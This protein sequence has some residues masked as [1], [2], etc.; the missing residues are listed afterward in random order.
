MPLAVGEKL[1]PYEILGPLGAGGMGAVYRARDTRLGREVAIKISSAQFTDR[2]EREARAVAALNHPNICHL[3]D[4]GALPSGAGYLVMELIEGQTLTDRIRQGPIPTEE[5]LH[6]AAQIRDALEAAHEKLITHRDLKPGNVM[7]TSES[8]SSGS[9][10]K[11]LDFGLAKQGR[12]GPVSGS[13]AAQSPT[14]SPTLSMAATEAGMILG[15][16]A[17][18]APE[19]AKGKPVDKRADIWAFG[20]VLYEMLTGERPF[21]GEDAGDILASVIKEQPKF[22]KVPAKVRPLIESCLEK[23]PN[24]RLRDIGDAWRL[25]DSGAASQAAAGLQ[26]GELPAHSHSRFGWIT[27]GPS[28]LLLIAVASLSFVHFRETHPVEQSL[29]YQIPPPGSAVAQYLALSPDGHN[30]AFVANNGGPNQVWVRAMDT[31]ESRALAGTDGATYP[32]WSPDGAYLGFFTDGK[33]KKIAVGGGPPQTLCDATSGRGGTWNRAGVILFSPGPASVIFRVPAAGGTPVPVTKLAGNG[34]GEGNRFPVFL[35]DGD[36]FVYNAGSDRPDAAGVFVGSL[37]GAAPVR[38]L[39]DVSNALYAPPAAQVA[40]GHLLFR[41]EGTLMAQPFDAKGLKTAGD[42]FPIAEQVPI[43]GNNGFGAFSVSGNGMLVFRSGGGATSREL[44]WMDR[45]GKRLGVLGKPGDF[46]GINVSP[47]EKTVAVRIGSGSQADIWL[48]DMARSVLSRFTFRS[49]IGTSAVWSP[50]GSRLAFALQTL[51]TYSS[52]IYQKPAG[53]NGQEELLL[54]AGINGYPE[55]WSPDGKWILYRQTGQKT[56]LDLWLLPLN[57]D[58]KPVPYLQTPFDEEFARFSPD[59]KW[60][61][62]Q[63]NESGRNQIYVQSV[64]P[65]RGEVPDLIGGRNGAPLEEGWPGVV[66]RLTRSEADGRASEARRDRRGWHAAAALP[67][68][69]DRERLTYAPMRDGQRFLVN[70]PA[71]GEAAAAVQPITVVTNWQAGL[72]K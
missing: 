15:T 38:L 2:F 46:A 58:R 31:L 70:V 37:N 39:P 72:K 34:G 36:H 24:K 35:P 44:A 45:T 9:V 20:V 63:S 30:L 26:P 40:F 13:E 54:H 43:S 67:D 59:G 7:I 60:M 55:D 18:M 69:T 56:A 32:F 48:E 61:A 68:P 64:P 41:R 8:S 25:L 49:G 19:Q 21:H 14:Q 23:D 42:A 11:V 50:D 33:L 16:A 27:W 52:D 4:V 17:Y 5:A 53:G 22:D 71:G 65:Q 6:I 1:G 66:L 3:Y 57:G 51:G 10:V 28:A 29:R 62:Y 47:D 12:E